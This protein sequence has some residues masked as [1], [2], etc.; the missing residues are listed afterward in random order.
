MDF[1]SMSEINDKL[2]EDVKERIKKYKKYKKTIFISSND[3]SCEPHESVLFFF[4]NLILIVS[5]FSSKKPIV[6]KKHDPH[7]KY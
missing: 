6:M 1:D 2:I 7:Y 4:T 3:T 5:I